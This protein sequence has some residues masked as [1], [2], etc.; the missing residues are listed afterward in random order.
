MRKLPRPTVPEKPALSHEGRL[1]AVAY[2][3]TDS[4][5]EPWPCVRYFETE[6]EALAFLVQ[7][8][9]SRAQP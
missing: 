1:W 8:E 3:R 4:G 7:L 9:T 2:A 5:T 6:A